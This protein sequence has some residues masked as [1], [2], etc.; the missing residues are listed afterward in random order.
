[1]SLVSESIN[2]VA[3]ISLLFI[4]YLEYYFIK[5][6]RKGEAFMVILTPPDK[7]T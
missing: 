2:N 1:M 3:L 5:Q 7:T 4:I 6:T